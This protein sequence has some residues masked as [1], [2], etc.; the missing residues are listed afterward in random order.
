MSQRCAV[1]AGPIVW[2]TDEPTRQQPRWRHVDQA[3][4]KLVGA[5]RAQPDEMQWTGDNAAALRAWAGGPFLEPRHGRLAAICSSLPD[6]TYGWVQLQVGDYV[7]RNDPDPVWVD[8]GGDCPVK[9]G[10]VYT[11]RASA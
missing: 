3:A 9:R 11:T 5:H 10:F 2:D 8:V 4:S 7:V 6:G 1:C